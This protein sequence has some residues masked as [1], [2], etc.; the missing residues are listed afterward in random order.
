MPTVPPYTPLG[1]TIHHNRANVVAGYMQDDWKIR[2]SLTLNLGLRYEMSTIPWETQDKIHYLPTIWYDANGCGSTVNGDVGCGNLRNV[3]FTSNPTLTNFEP[4]IGF[5]WDPFHNGK[6]S[7]RGGFGIFDV[8]PLPYMIGLNALQ[9]APEGVEIDLSNPGQGT[10][11]SQ[12][13]TIALAQ[14][15]A[16]GIPPA[17]SLRWSYVTPDP[18]RNYSEQWNLNVQRQLTSDTACETWI[19]CLYRNRPRRDLATGSRS[20]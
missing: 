19:F 11:P 6:T 16:T 18:K 12:L 1:D 15:A 13:G 17:S 4:R 5:A 14:A 3:T 2:P 10:Y 7:V 9:T 20:G 8:L